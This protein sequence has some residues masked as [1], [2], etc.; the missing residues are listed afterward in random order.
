VADE[1]GIGIAALH[2]V[3]PEEHRGEHRYLGAAADAQLQQAFAHYAVCQR[4]VIRSHDFAELLALEHGWR[5]Y[6]VPLLRFPLV[7]D[8]CLLSCHK[9]FLIKF[10]LLTRTL[11]NA[12]KITDF[13]F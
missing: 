10:L 13:Y 5:F 12:I 1:D 2:V 11:V 9:N 8:F 7:N 4:L 6:R 3:Y